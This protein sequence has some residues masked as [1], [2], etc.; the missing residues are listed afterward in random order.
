MSTP[1]KYVANLLY[2]LR[3]EPL[4]YGVV[5]VDTEGRLIG[6]TD[7]GG[8]L[9]ES[10]RMEYHSGILFPGFRDSLE[11]TDFHFLHE[12]TNNHPD[13]SNLLNTLPVDRS[14]TGKEILSLLARVQELFP[15]LSLDTLLRRL[16]QRHAFTP[17]EPCRLYLISRADLPNRR[18]TALSVLKKLV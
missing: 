17:G 1:R 13:V 3:S 14:L 7:T 8:Q 9:R 16:C 2:S 6:I 18:I 10:E 5:E 15:E 12:L 4:R 11:K